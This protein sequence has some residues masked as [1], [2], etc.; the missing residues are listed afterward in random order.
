MASLHLS[1]HGCDALSLPTSLDGLKVSLCAS[2]QP[3]PWLD[4]V[5][6]TVGNPVFVEPL[7]W[8][9]GALDYVIVDSWR[10]QKLMC[11]SR[12]IIV[13]SLI[14]IHNC[15]CSKITW[16][17]WND[18][19]QCWDRLARFVHNKGFEVCFWSQIMNVTYLI[20]ISQ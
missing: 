5:W 7:D 9:P 19:I 20:E 14:R 1:G 3:W 4:L 16:E 2:S 11:W 10:N 15:F 8:F 17:G 18:T 12:Y 6:I 13:T